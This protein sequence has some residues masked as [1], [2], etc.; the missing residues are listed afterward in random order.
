MPPG[1]QSPGSLQSNT[2]LLKFTL[3]FSLA[4]SALETS[5][6]CAYTCR[7]ELQAGHIRL[8]AAERSLGPSACIYTDRPKAQSSG[9]GQARVDLVT[10][11]CRGWQEAL[12]LLSMQEPKAAGSHDGCCG[13]CAAKKDLLL[14]RGVSVNSVCG[15]D[16][17]VTASPAPCWGVCGQSGPWD[18]RGAV[19]EH[20]WSSACSMA[21]EE[22][23]KQRTC[24]CAQQQGLDWFAA[25]V[26][27][28]AV[29][30][31]L[32]EF[33]CFS[34]SFIFL[35]CK[36]RW[37][38]VSQLQRPLC[39]VFQSHQVTQVPILGSCRLHEL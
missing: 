25:E 15:L 7:N 35:S 6:G 17:N 23:I 10:L 32:T 37:L 4:P 1:K 30:F 34:C 22:G 12:W 8:V 26:A 39:G 33:C 3:Q 5:L 18:T 16:C 11:R 38:W 31:S 9:K 13:T 36:D 2:D 28:F 24:S 20:C 14:H 21:A 19:A 29:H 27:Y